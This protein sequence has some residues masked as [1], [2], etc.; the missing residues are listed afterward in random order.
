MVFPVRIVLSVESSRVDE[1]PEM[2]QG[3]VVHAGGEH[4]EH[5]ES[6]REAASHQRLHVAAA[7]GCMPAAFS[8]I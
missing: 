2:G 4:G 1:D 7:S 3:S 8:C 5:G 6:R